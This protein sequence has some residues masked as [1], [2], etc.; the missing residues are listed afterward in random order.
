MKS[1]YSVD[2]QITDNMTAV[3][4]LF[5]CPHLLTLDWRTGSWDQAK[6]TSLL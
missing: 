4:Y 3:L 6:V 2:Q 5:I 1:I